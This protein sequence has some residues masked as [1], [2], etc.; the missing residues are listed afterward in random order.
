M[1][2]GISAGILNRFGAELKEWHGAATALQRRIGPDARCFVP[3]SEGGQV[4]V[5]GDGSPILDYEFS[6]TCGTAFVRAFISMAEMQLQPAQ[7]A[8]AGT[9]GRPRLQELER[10]QEQIALLPLE[11]FRTMLFTA[12][13]MGGCGMSENPT[14]GVVNSR[15]RH[16]Q[17]SNL[18]VMDG[19][20]FPTSLGVNPQLT[21]FGLVAQNATALAQ[22]LGGKVL[23]A[24]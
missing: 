1:A 12:H 2:V 24:P 11:K 20:T 13:L 5:G 19:S 7:R 21:I 14:T 16:H 10:S 22:E 18:S 17:L 8:F 15:G 23:S 9:P 3:Q 4:R 6:L